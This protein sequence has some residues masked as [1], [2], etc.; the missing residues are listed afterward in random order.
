MNF[1]NYLSEEISVAYYVTPGV[2]LSDDMSKIVTVS[3]FVPG[4]VGYELGPNAPWSWI[5][6][7][8]AVK[9]NGA[10]WG[11]Y[12]HRSMKYA[13]ENPKEYEAYP[14]WN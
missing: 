13:V 2:E 9:A 5:L 6:D 1:V 3:W 11:Q 7:E 8:A 10:F 12:R 14:L 4:V